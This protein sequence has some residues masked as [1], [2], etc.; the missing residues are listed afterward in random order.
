VDGARLQS[1]RSW[2]LGEILLIALL[3]SGTALFAAS[4]SLQSAYELHDAR[5]AF[6]TA[7]AV[8]AAIVCVLASVRFLVDGRTL[9]LL[10]AAG[11]WS[12]ALGTVAF[13]LAPVLGGGVLT[14]QSAWALVGARLLGAGLIAIAP[15]VGG[16]MSSRRPSLLA[17]AVGVVLVL[18]GAGIGLGV[19]DW[20][21][22]SLG[23]DVVEGL[24][25]QVAGALLAMLWLVALIGFGLRYR[26]YGR[27][28]DSWMCLA[29]TLALFADIH[30]VL[31]PVVSSDYVL[32]GDFLRVIAYGILLV[33]VWRAISDAEFGRAV[34]D[35][36]ARVAREIH[37]GLAQYLFAISTQV[38]MLESG[39]P[40]D[41]VLP[42]LKQAATAA[43][44]EARFAV[45]ALSSAGGSARFDSALRR[46]VELL[47]ADGALDVELEV[48]PQVRL[49]PDEQIEVFRIV[50]EGLGNARRHSGAGHVEVS[51]SHQGGRR[52]VS[53]SDDGVGFDD[54][55]TT[56][57]QGVANM[58]LRALAIDGE[59]SL[60]SA[61]GRGTAIEVVLRAA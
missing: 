61:P 27:D 58:R 16:R 31:T 32:Q 59:L 33:G 43:Q 17:V 21:G 41:H 15:Y 13:G 56:S 50:Q 4:E 42:R 14:P 29:A 49:A 54:A 22:T 46:Y 10:L 2:L 3:A 20:G 34:A 39:A 23:A 51:I 40:L 36:R 5:I 57:G 48:D 55:V 37:D 9:D 38:S 44:Q 18:A 8:V 25:V 28:L 12:I 24:Y 11:F 19:P 52:V 35:E 60:K 30:L 26:R 47:T 45:L 7:I 1:Y 53:V 6:D